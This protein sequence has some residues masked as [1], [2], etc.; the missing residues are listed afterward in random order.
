MVR[1]SIEAKVRTRLHRAP[2]RSENGTIEPNR[3][4]DREVGFPGG[5]RRGGPSK[6]RRANPIGQGAPPGLASFGSGRGRA[7]RN[8]K[9]E[10][11]NPNCEGSKGPQRRQQPESK[12]FPHKNVTAISRS[13]SEHERRIENATIEPNRP[14]SRDGGFPGGRRRIGVG[15]P[16]RSNPIVL[17]VATGSTSSASDESASRKRDDRTQ[18]PGGIWIDSGRVS[19]FIGRPGGNEDPGYND[20]KGYAWRTGCSSRSPTRTRSPT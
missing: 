8:R 5:R 3:P 16:R 15:K 6:T 2:T 12:V 10:R 14:E 1:S 7:A 17:R 18:S 13:G 19:G 20:S 4:V 11:S 9:T